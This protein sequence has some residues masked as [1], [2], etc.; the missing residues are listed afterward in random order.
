MV[1]CFIYVYKA[2]FLARLSHD[3]KLQVT[4]FRIV[5]HKNPVKDSKYHYEINVRAIFDAKSIRS[6]TA[7][8]DG[9][10]SPGTL[11][12][13]EHSIIEKLMHCC[14]VKADKFPE[15]IFESSGFSVRS[16]RLC[17]EGLLTLC[18]VCRPIIM[19]RK[20]AGKLFA[21]ETTLHQPDFGIKPFRALM[22]ALEIRPDVR[23]E[24]MALPD[25]VERLVKSKP[26][27]FEHDFR[28]I[29]RMAKK[30]C[31]ERLAGTKKGKRRGAV[32]RPTRKAIKI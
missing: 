14:V 5:L 16:K 4:R 32:K 28:T 19:M 9:M 10:E 24:L 21:G 22:G 2:G 1:D 6:I 27:F 11:K 20:K 15:I 12:M 26:S 17:I 3:L 7:M 13:W 25:K 29:K 18:G 30:I 8:K 23:V 31:S